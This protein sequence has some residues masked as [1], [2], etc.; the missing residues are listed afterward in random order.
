MPK[1]MMLW[2][3]FNFL[4]IMMTRLLVTGQLSK[5]YTSRTA[6]L[7]RTIR[8]RWGCVFIGAVGCHSELVNL[9]PQKTRLVS[10]RRSPLGWPGPES[11]RCGWMAAREGQWDA[12]LLHSS[13]QRWID[14]EA[15]PR[16]PPPG[17]I[18]SAALHLDP[19]FILS[20][21]TNSPN[22]EGKKKS[23][24]ISEWLSMPR[25]PVTPWPRQRSDKRSRKGLLFGFVGEWQ[26]GEGLYRQVEGDAGWSDKALMGVGIS[27]MK[28]G[29]RSKLTILIHFESVSTKSP[30][31]QTENKFI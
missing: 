9:L 16:P 29:S 13:L 17:R 12:G 20:P 31:W 26:K 11:D 14:T 28:L 6:R 24:S 7:P 19:R 15:R 25:V 1:G 23:I 5:G 22:K 27:R 4:V 21:Y 10:K 2:A 3:I 30:H 8:R 18:L